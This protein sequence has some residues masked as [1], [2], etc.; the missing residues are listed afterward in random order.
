VKFAAIVVASV[1]IAGPSYAQAP[2]K[3]TLEDSLGQAVYVMSTDG[4]GSIGMRTVLKRV[5]SDGMELSPE[6]RALLEKLAAGHP[7]IIEG[8]EL[9]RETPAPNA[10]AAAMAAMALAPPDLATIEPVAAKL[11]SF[12]E[13]HGWSEA[14]KLA[15]V[16]AFQA[17]LASSL[18]GDASGAAALA[19]VKA[20]WA[21][22]ASLSGLEQRTSAWEMIA[23]GCVMA[24]REAGASAAAL[25][26]V[27]QWTQDQPRYNAMIVQGVVVP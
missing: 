15:S 8:G 16:K 27:C 23:Y 1:L 3:I 4:Y 10:E 20:Y 7:L 26:P 17:K 6:E 2:V 5:F 9:A 21:A 11:T 13:M 19:L 24:Q 12:V 14:H 18:S 25:S 22:A